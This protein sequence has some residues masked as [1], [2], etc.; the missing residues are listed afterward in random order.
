MAK[1]FNT[2]ALTHFE[3]LSRKWLFYDVI[4]GGGQTPKNLI[5]YDKFLKNHSFFIGFWQNLAKTLNA[6]ILTYFEILSWKQPFYDVIVEGKHLKNWYFRKKSHKNQPFFVWLSQNLAKSL[7][8]QILTFFDVLSLAWSLVIVWRHNGASTTW[9]CVVL[10]KKLKQVYFSIFWI[11]ELNL[12]F[13]GK[14]TS[15]RLIFTKFDN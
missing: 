10:Q 13:S 4:M 2:Y 14:M 12:I 9:K 15:I 6:N 7:N 1:K 8:T 5:F 11:F 3:I